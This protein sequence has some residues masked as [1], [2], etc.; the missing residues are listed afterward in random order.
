MKKLIITAVCAGAVAGVAFSQGNVN[1]NTLSAA[2]I[3]WQT[4]STTVSSLFGGGTAVGGSVGAAGGSASQGTGFYYELLVGSVYNGTVAS[5]PTTIAGLASWT[6]SGLEATNSNTAGRVTT[7]N[8]NAGATVASISQ[9]VSNNI[10]LVGWSAN[11]GTTWAAALANLQ[12]WSTFSQT[13]TSSAFLGFSSAGYVE[14]VATS[15]SPGAT[16][17]GT[18]ATS[19][20]LPIDSLNTPLYILP[21]PEPGTI[22]LAALGGASL[23][24]F[25]RKK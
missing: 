25:R 21:I 19:Q 14:G 10:I 6:D 9:T 23:L 3:T 15:I 20:G 16:V 11:L 24:L 4:N 7:I 1:W 2:A 12:N 5:A 13:L 22:A 18:G 17:I 8:P